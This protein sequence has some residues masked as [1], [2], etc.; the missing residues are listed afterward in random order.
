MK[1]LSFIIIVIIIL[2]PEKW[3]F[4]YFT[5]KEIASLSTASENDPAMKITQERIE[6]LPLPVAR[7]LMNIGLAGKHEIQ[8]VRLKQTG[9]MKLKP[10]QKKWY[11]SNAEQYIT[12]KEPAFLWKAEIKMLPFINIV[13]RDLFMNGRGQMKIKLASIIPIVN[14]ADNEKLNQSTLQRY[15]LE[16]PWYPS[17]ALS[18]YIQWKQIGEFSA[19]ATMDYNGVSGS[20]I[21]QFSAKGNVE[22]ISAHRYKDSSKNAKLPECVGEVVENSNI[23]GINI[24][25]TLNVSWMLDEGKFTWYKVKVKDIRFNEQQ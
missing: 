4:N 12:V 24:P 19:E 10:S 5:N 14:I 7:W 21:Y 3:L 20:A 17:A 13:G 16:L 15:L 9:L 2:I 6:T 23:E 25:T 8:S 22:K 11:Q 18:P 1:F